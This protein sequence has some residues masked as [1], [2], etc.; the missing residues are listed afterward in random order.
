M[1]ILKIETLDDCMFDTVTME[2]TLDCPVSA[3]LI[4]KLGLL[5]KLIYYPKFDIPFYRVLAEPKY[6]L[7]G[8]ETSD[9]I[10]VIFLKNTEAD[11][12]LKELSAYLEH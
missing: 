11:R 9:K 6:I 3:T 7:K 5:G 8:N 10:K 12:Y 2:L 4:K 1:R